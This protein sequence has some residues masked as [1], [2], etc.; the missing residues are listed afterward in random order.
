MKIIHSNLSPQESIIP[1]HAYVM[2]S[3]FRM[4]YYAF[5][6]IEM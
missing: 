2:V 3:I 6:R 1:P 5:L 4:R